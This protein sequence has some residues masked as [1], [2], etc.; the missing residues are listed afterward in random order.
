MTDEL[1]K[2][3]QLIKE[4]CTKRDDSIVFV[5]PKHESKCTGCPLADGTGECG[6]TVDSPDRWK[7]EKGRYIF[8]E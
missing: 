2:A 5:R 4:E 6:V 1:L 8:N 7:L 3:L